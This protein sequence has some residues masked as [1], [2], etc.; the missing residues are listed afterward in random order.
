[1]LPEFA[2][3]FCFSNC[4][5][6]SDLINLN[7]Q[8]RCCSPSF[9]HPIAL[10]AWQRARSH[11][12]AD[13]PAARGAGGSAADPALHLG[14]PS[15]RQRQRR[16]YYRARPAMAGVTAVTFDPS[17]GDERLRLRADRRG[18]GAVVQVGDLH[19]VF[20]LTPANQPSCNQPQPKRV[21][22]S[23][24]TDSSLVRRDNLLPDLQMWMGRRLSMAHFDRLL[25]ERPPNDVTKVIMIKN[26]Q[27]RCWFFNQ[28]QS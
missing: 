8:W 13:M 11:V 19:V 24:P 16:V 2:H 9:A 18:H 12:N 3:Q 26:N 10:F 1:M 27:V 17:A 21:T 25:Q 7:W 20:A 22:V 23:L 4:W 5:T 15:Q 6:E 14:G 28:L